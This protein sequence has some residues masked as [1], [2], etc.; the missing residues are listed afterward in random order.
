[1]TPPGSERVFVCGASGS[2][3]TEFLRTRFLP[4]SPRLLIVDQTGEWPDKEP[5][6]PVYMG[7]EETLGGLKGLASQP[8]W[9]AICYL[10]PE[11]VMRLSEE[12]L[13]P[14]GKISQGYSYSV[15]GMGLLLDEVD[16]LV[17]I[18]NAPL[19]L[20]SLWR[21]SRHGGLTVFAA[22]QRPGNV[23]KEVTSQCRWLGVLRQHEARDVLYLASVIDRGL[24]KWV[25]PE[26]GRREYSVFLWDNVNRQGYLFD[27]DGNLLRTSRPAQQDLGL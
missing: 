24:M 21:R 11:E 9:R 12:V 16:S 23:S 22:T 1:M 7:F 25:L 19:P 4:R 20:R 17:P 8:K 14:P 18:A 15:G 5:E 26:L 3:K 10:E 2:G 27:R 13:L 6:A